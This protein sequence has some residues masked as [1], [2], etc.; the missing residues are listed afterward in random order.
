MP[1]LT[2]LTPTGSGL[3]GDLFVII[4]DA[5]SE[6]LWGLNASGRS[7]KSLTLDYFLDNGYESIPALGPLPVSVPGCLDGWFEM[8]KKF[9]SISMEKILAP[10]IKYAREGFPV[11]ELIAYYMGRSA[12]ALQKFPGFKE[13]IVAYEESKEAQEMA[14]QVIF[15]GR[16][17]SGK[18]PV[19]AGEYKSGEGIS[20]VEP[21]RL[22]YGSIA[23]LG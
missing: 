22:S 16:S 4:W 21:L 18:L 23:E 6:K 9:G 15:G 10:T 12:N 17:A 3:G 1:N 7:P 19:S 5:K 20:T 11:S 13:L 14:A 2:K 8:H